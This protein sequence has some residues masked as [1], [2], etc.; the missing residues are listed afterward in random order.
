MATSRVQT[1][2]QTL[3]TALVA[4]SG[5]AGVT[6]FRYAATPKAIEATRQSDGRQ[7]WIALA[8]RVPVEPRHPFTTVQIRHDSLTLEG[9]VVVLLPGI[10]DDA[11]DDAH[12]RAAALFAELEDE[13]RT[14]KSLGLAGLLL[15]LGGHT[16]TYGGSDQG[17]A[18]FL[19]FAITVQDRLVSV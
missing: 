16:H 18:H 5:L 15:T 6:I 19:T 1:I 12:T 7:E 9:E 13:L 10:G 8:N 14:N 4:R 2:I 11:A 3:Q 17:R